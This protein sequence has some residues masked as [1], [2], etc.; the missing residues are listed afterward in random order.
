MAYE[1][2]EEPRYEIVPEPAKI[3][4]EGLP[5]AVKAVAGNFNPLTQAAVGAKGM[6]DNAAMKLK[7]AWGGKLT[8]EEETY[9]RANRALFESS[10]PALAGGAVASLGALPV[11]GPASAFVASRLGAALP[12]LSQWVLPAAT[13]GMVANTVTS[14][15][16]PGDRGNA[17]DE[18]AVGGVVGE[19]LM[20]GGSRVVQPILHS[21][22]V[23]NLLKQG[24]V[25][26]PGSAIGG[27]ARDVEDKFTSVPLVGNLIN[28]ARTRSLEDMSR[29][30]FKQATPPGQSIPEVGKEGVQLGK[31]AFD[32]AYGGVY[33]TS[34]IG[35]SYDLLQGIG[36]AKQG[37]T[38]PLSADEATKFD[39]IIKREVLD[40]LSDGPVMTAD[41][42]VVIEKNLREAAFKA[43]NS[44]LGD[45]L[46]GALRSFRDAM[47]RS[48][49]P[50]GQK[51]LQDIDRAYSAFSDVKKAVDRA[52]ANAGLF[53]PHQ[54]QMTSKSGSSLER[55][56]DD[57]QQVLPSKV[58]NSGTVDRGLSSLLYL[59]GTTGAAAP[60]FGVP[61]WS[62]LAAAPLLYSRPGTR[63]LLGDLLPGQGILAEGI[64]GAAP[65]GA[66]AGG[67]L[68]ERY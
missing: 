17:A 31:Q 8:P 54:L 46:K 52:D 34:R 49:G 21:P 62:A 9:V 22:A 41:A 56:A 28:N 7:Q 64:R 38:I 66:A 51:Q 23:S 57:A 16:L 20:R 30:A 3:G 68:G 13:T 67:V 12:R 5:D 48:V 36:A 1:L 60:I 37:T 11:A 44:P 24:V 27:L 2:V 47:G 40:R 26:T 25:P 53:T 19:G 15:T 58:P 29:A 10:M 65:Y 50:G 55:L 43:G 32:R 42:K 18:G 33:G 63:Y 59:G 45:A 6:W 39:A 4:V 14:P 35:L 61:Y